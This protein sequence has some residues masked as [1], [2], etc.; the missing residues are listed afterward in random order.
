LIRLLLNDAQWERIELVGR[1]GSRAARSAPTLPG[2][3]Q[4]A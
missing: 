2:P 4:Q 3:G 1:D